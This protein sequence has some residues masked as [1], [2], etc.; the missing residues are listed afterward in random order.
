MIEIIEIFFSNFFLIGWKSGELMAELETQA[1]PHSFFFR[2]RPARTWLR[3]HWSFDAEGVDVEWREEKD[4][5][6]LPDIIVYFPEQTNP[7]LEYPNS[8]FSYNGIEEPQLVDVP[9]APRASIISG[10]LF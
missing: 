9:M 1:Q 8:L 7:V 10:V 2:E 5:H 6:F 3:F 4:G